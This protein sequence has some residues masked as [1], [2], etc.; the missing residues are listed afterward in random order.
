MSD[1]LAF[2]R[3][4]VEQVLLPFWM[5]AVD[6]VHGG[7]FTCFDNR[8]VTRVSTDK[9]TWSQ[10]RFVWLWSR[11][12]RMMRDGML[13]GDA[14]LFLAQAGQAVSFLR[15]HVFLPY[16]NCMYVL[17]ADGEAKS[18]DASLYADCFVLLGFSEYAAVS[19]DAETL[20][21][22][23]A[24]YDRLVA[25]LDT[26]D[27]RTDPYP[28]P[29]GY[30]AHSLA[31]VKLRFTQALRAAARTL[32][33]ARA[34]ELAVAELA[35]VEVLLDTFA[36][37]DGAVLEMIPP[38]P[39]E[40]D[41]ILARHATPGHT[42]ESMWFVLRTAVSNRKPEWVERA[43][44][45]IAWAVELGWDEE[46]GGLYRYTDRE[47]GRPRG[48]ATGNGYEALMM[49]TWDTKIWWPHSEAVFSTL[50][51]ATVSGDEALRAWHA[52]VHE[53]VFRTFPNPDRAVGEWIQIRDR[54]GA[55]LDK[56]VALPVK[57]PYHI[58]QN[59]LLCVELLYTK[60]A[61]MDYAATGRFEG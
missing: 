35:A 21:E 9:Y 27:F 56:C 41:T 16:G 34:E 23:M 15:R 2:Y 36:Q 49:D 8:G 30:R 7:I 54:M 20:D 57:D 26:G 46:F 1:L 10:G 22:A 31:M 13:T 32:G 11:A 51:A 4:H 38:G 14:E 25:R 60:G 12:A 19:G 28:I 5:P 6:T 29:A 59:L 53:Y 43:C 33:H 50:A 42:L 58:L 55:P 45:S 52:R 40:A 17:G 37:A 61:T 44:R 47:G 18:D 24:I 3:D 48:V 39:A